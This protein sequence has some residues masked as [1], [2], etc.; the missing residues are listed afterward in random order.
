[1]FLSNN[2]DFAE[3]LRYLWGMICGTISAKG[4][5]AMKYTTVNVQQFANQKG[6]PWQARAKYK[7]KWKE[8]NVA[9]SKRQERS[10]ANGKGMV[11]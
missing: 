10:Y 11:R 4:D 3:H 8:V 5:L 6:K 9:R 1:M 2:L 7:G